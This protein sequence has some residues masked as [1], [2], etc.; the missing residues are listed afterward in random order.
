MTQRR[1]LLGRA[2]QAVLDSWDH[3]STPTGPGIDPSGLSASRASHCPVITVRYM[4]ELSAPDTPLA[5][6][7]DPLDLTTVAST[8]VTGTAPLQDVF[9]DPLDVPRAI[10]TLAYLRGDLPH[11]YTCSLHLDSLDQAIEVSGATL[12][13]STFEPKDERFCALLALPAAYIVLDGRRGGTDVQVYA[14]SPEAARAIGEQL[15]AASQPPARADDEVKMSFVYGSSSGPSIRERHIT[16]PT[17]D[18]LATNYSASASAALAALMS[19]SRPDGSGRLMLFH[20]PPGTGKTTAIRA[21][22]RAWTPWCDLSYIMDPEALFSSMDYL[23]SVVL[24]EQINADRWR[25]FVIEDADE[26]IAADAKSRTGQALSRLLNLTDGIVGQ[27]LN[28]LFLITTNEP[29]GALHPA[30]TRPGR[31][32]ADIHVGPLTVAE[33][34]AW[35]AAHGHHATMTTPQTL[36]ELFDLLAPTVTTALPDRSIAPASGMYL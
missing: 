7:F 12:L 32:L 16:S 25:L 1:R 9:G 17:W 35:L 15:A 2:S 18:E 6:S 11:I 5:P 31:C 22:A 8:N 21:L 19:T 33:C 27:G 4:A 24:D 3:R 13:R 14:T 29:L 28:A 26:I 23:Q 10:G 36:A 30:V 34:Q 20:G